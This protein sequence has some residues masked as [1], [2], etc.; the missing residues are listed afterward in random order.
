MRDLLETLLAGSQRLVELRG[1]AVVSSCLLRLRPSGRSLNLLDGRH[2]L[3]VVEDLLRVRV[4][5]D[6]LLLVLD[7]FEQLPVKV[8][9]DVQ[10]LLE[11]FC[12]SLHRL[13]VRLAPSSILLLEL[14]VRDALRLVP[15]CRSSGKRTNKT[16]R[17][18][19]KLQ[20]SFKQ[21]HS[22]VDTYCALKKI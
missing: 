9:F 16:L 20:L 19:L 11:H 22:A 6:P 13:L 4:F 14:H 5:R 12:Y 3:E 17:W 15:S 7:V 2:V 8:A 18:E 1:V 21:S 10:V